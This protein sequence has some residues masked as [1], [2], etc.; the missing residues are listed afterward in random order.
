M[1][2]HQQCAVAAAEIAFEPLNHFEVEM[3]G[4]LIEN[5]EIRFGDQYVGK[6]YT[7]LLST[8]QL[9]HGLG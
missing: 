9:P 3:V 7:L 8:A 4:G 1:G 5:K 6:G 2:D